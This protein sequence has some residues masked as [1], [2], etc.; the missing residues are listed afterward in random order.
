MSK[1]ALLLDLFLH[2]ATGN[3][4]LNSSAPKW[5]ANWSAVDV[6]TLLGFPIAYHEYRLRVFRAIAFGIDATAIVGVKVWTPN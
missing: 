6:H 4:V 2:V 5:H 1:T 3:N